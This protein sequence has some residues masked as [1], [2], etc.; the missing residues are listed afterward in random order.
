MHQE[1]NNAINSQARPG[2]CQVCRAPLDSP[3]QFAD[4]HLVCHSLECKTLLAQLNAAPSYETHL[5]HFER[6]AERLRLRR[7]AQNAADAH[8]RDVDA[9]EALDDEARIGILS[10]AL[11]ELTGCNIPVINI[12]ASTHGAQPLT[13]DR[14]NRYRESLQQAISE[15]FAD[16]PIEDYALLDSQ[17]K[18][19]DVSKLLSIKPNAKALAELG[20]QLCKGSCCS[21]GKDTGF[22]SLLTIQRAT[23][24]LKTESPEELLAAYLDRLPS[25]VIGQSCINHGVEG[26]V[27][28]RDMRSDICNGYFCDSLKDVI[29]TI[30]P[31]E[32]PANAVLIQR[33]YELWSKYDE[34]TC[35]DITRVVLVQSGNA[36]DVTAD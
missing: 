12:P 9:Q 18:Q 2:H 19:E 32:Q 33:H 20:C 29:H 7:Q 10:Q 1:K 14:I 27:L 26:C 6:Q 35:H 25:E 34:Q 13:E 8:A 16:P 22:V 23:Q 3:I 30:E 24:Y 11:P 17:R 36:R 5:P 4:A 15:A 31:S 21:A 28:P